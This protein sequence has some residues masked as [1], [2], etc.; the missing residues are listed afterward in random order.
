[1]KRLF[2]IALLLVAIFTVCPVYANDAHRLGLGATYW[3]TVDDVDV[4]NIDDDGFSFIAS[5]Q[6]WP[7]LVG[8]E[9]NLEIMPD[10]YGENAFSPQAYVLVGKAIYAGAGIGIDYRD[11]D[12]SEEPFFALRAG[13]N[14]EIL[15]TI[16]WDIY[17]TYR[18]NDSADLDDEE[19]DI[20]SD[21]V[22]LGTA[23]RFAF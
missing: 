21:T 22:Y 5:Y 13:L 2:F 17:G 8:V 1:M 6:Y 16:Y 11:G 12:F 20:D 9:L 19:K 23:L 7:T 10:K 15:P 14:L 4:D 3:T 18:F